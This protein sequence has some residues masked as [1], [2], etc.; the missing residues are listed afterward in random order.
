MQNIMQ[1]VLTIFQ[2]NKR[3]TLWLILISLSI[4]LGY[5]RSILEIRSSWS[6]QPAHDFYGDM[7]KGLSD[8]LRDEHYLGYYTDGDPADAKIMA[9]FEQTQLMLVPIV[10]DLNNTAHKFVLFDCL[11]IN[12]CVERINNIKARPVKTTPSGVIL[13]VTTG[14]RN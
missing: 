11:D 3:G 12:A 8:A 5:C 10:L 1:K 13:A 14:S 4:A 7:F 9:R 2:H 6:K